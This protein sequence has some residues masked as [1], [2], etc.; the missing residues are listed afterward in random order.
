MAITRLTQSTLQQAFPKFPSAWDGVSAVSSIDAISGVTLTNSQASIDFNSIPQT[1]QHLQIRGILRSSI[2]ANQ[3]TFYLQF[4]GDNGNNYKAHTLMAT[5]SAPTSFAT[6]PANFIE[7]YQIPG[8]S[9][10][11]GIFGTFV[12]DIHDYSNTNKNKIVT[13]SYA[14]D[15]NSA[16][17][18]TTN[19]FFSGL[20]MNTNAVT[21][22]KFASQNN[23]SAVANSSISVYG[24]R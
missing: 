21:S 3:D 20:W 5:G 22:I 17:A 11:A 6:G 10:T 9:Q 16:N 15:N 24:I 1:Y 19:A 8:A 2:S 18:S 7:F 4:N 12:I 23:N 14:M 13:I